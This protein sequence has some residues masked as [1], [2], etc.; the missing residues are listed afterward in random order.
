MTPVIALKPQDARDD[1][2]EISP[3][4]TAANDNSDLYDQDADMNQANCFHT[5]RVGVEASGRNT[6][7]SCGC[8]SQ[9]TKRVTAGVNGR[10]PSV[11][12]GLFHEQELSTH[13]RSA[14]IPPQI[15]PRCRNIN[16][17]T[18]GST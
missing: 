10:N 18:K 9:H 14:V 8:L 12:R 3:V 7:E 5:T 16:K 2:W 11:L 1:A 15:S 17:P 13:Q 6:S 4:Q